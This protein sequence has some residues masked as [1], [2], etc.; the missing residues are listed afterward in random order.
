MKTA[1]E[2]VLEN[3]DQFNVEIYTEFRSKIE[4]FCY[5]Y[6]MLCLALTVGCIKNLNI[7][8]LFYHLEILYLLV[9]SLIPIRLEHYNETFWIS[10]ML[11]LNF[12]FY[13]DLK[14]NM[15]SL[16]AMFIIFLYWIDV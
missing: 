10:I 5:I 6:P 8:R 11:M 9:N 3:T 13:V 16:L 2:L 7:A 1:D 14:L 12:I 4:I 15:L